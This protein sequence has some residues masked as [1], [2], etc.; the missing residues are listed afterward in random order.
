MEKHSFKMK[1]WLYQL[2]CKWQA[3]LLVP[4]DSSK[5]VWRIPKNQCEIAMEYAV[6]I[7]EKLQRKLVL[8]FL[9]ADNWH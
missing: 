3:F 7:T 2:F 1:P 4:P 8:G 6:Q 5:I 9:A